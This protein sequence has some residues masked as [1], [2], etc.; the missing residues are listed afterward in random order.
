MKHYYPYYLTFFALLFFSSRSPGQTVI[1]GP[2]LQSTT[3]NSI[4]VKW[5]TDIA[6]D[7]K[8]WYGNSPTNLNLTITDGVSKTEHEMQISGLSANTLYYY[9]IGN[10]SG[11]L[12]FPNFFHHFETLPTPGSTQLVNAWV[13]GD[14]GNRQQ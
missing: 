12:V 1:R 7:S 5:R 10:S 2:Y 3:T 13:L 9:T 14:C 8:V 6:T 11:Q 4:V